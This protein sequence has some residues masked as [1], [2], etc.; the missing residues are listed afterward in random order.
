MSDTQRNFLIL[1]ALAL[2]GVMFSGAFGTGAGI[3]FLLLN[4]AFAVLIV[5]FLI[6]LYQRNSGTIALMPATPRLVMQAASAGVLI[7]VV[8]GMF[9]LPF[10]PPPFGW[11]ADYPVVFWGLLLGCAFAVWWAWQQRTSRW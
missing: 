4:A 1:G 5:W 6:T 2:A 9:H 3:A 11:S 7:L 8:T 10:L